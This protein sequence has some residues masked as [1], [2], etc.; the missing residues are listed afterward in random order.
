M[1][2]PPQTQPLLVGITLLVLVIAVILAAGW[3]QAGRE[4]QSGEE[5]PRSLGDPRQM[6]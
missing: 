5:R 3:R 4:P 6:D 1:A 2:D